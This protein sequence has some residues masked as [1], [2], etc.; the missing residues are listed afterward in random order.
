MS[1]AA[2]N[3][4]YEKYRTKFDYYIFNEDDYYFNDHNFDTY[5]I[6]K[7]KSY[8]NIGYLATMIANPAWNFPHSLTHAGNSIGI[9]SSKILEELYKNLD[10]YLIKNNK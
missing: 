6:N 2:F 1:Y 3:E 4:V 9:T 5:L 8:S 7:F 10:V